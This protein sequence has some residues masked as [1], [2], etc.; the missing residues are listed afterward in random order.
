MRDYYTITFS[1]NLIK[2]IFFGVSIKLI[3]LTRHRHLGNS[4][5]D[6]MQLSSYHTLV[7][8]YLNSVYISESNL[9]FSFNF[10]IISRFIFKHFK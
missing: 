8:Y 3:G 1:R 4:E 7:N 9:R 10:V 2:Y 6:D 5:P